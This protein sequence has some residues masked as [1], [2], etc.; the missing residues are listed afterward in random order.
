MTRRLRVLA[1]LA[2]L[3]PAAAPAVVSTQHPAAFLVF[4]LVVV[5]L[6][7]DTLVQLTNVEDAAR[8]VTC[9]YQN[10]SAGPTLTSFT[11][12]LLANQPVAWRASSG[13]AAVPGGGGAVPPL[14]SE[15]FTGVLRCAAVD[16]AGA[17]TDAGALVGVATLER[18]GAPAELDAASYPATA[19]AAR[20]GAVSTDRRLIL[21]GPET[22]AEYD[23]CPQ[24]LHVPVLFDGATL[25]LGVGGDV[26]RTAST[27]L[28]LVTCTAR[29]GTATSSSVVITAVNEFGQQTQFL[30]MVRDQTVLSLTELN[31]TLRAGVQGSASGT[32][33]I[34]PQSAAG[35]GMLALAVQSFAGPLGGPGHGE[36]FSPQ[37]IGER[38]M[39][40]VVELPIPVTPLPTPTATGSPTV[41]PRV[42]AGD[43]NGDGV[44]AINELITGVNI[45]LG[46]QPVSTCTA[47]DANADG[48]VRV[49][50][51][52]TA[53]GH[54]LTGCPGA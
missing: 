37:L 26:Q 43:C 32:I 25:A 13:L 50:E 10:P 2:A 39:A 28:A 21:G 5:D 19:F 30:Q 8:R 27:T 42:C 14:G 15:R 34:S 38:E 44:V 36:A 54:A 31:A 48:A 17:P 51:L 9:A 29:S 23:G 45:A 52:I 46:N 20:A 4:P 53:V 3:L 1:V 18:G 47:F 24:T 11:I 35:P 16:A 7:A 6:P 40:D 22:E 49:N 33:R 41:T 12:E